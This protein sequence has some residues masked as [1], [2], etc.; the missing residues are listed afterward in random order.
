MNQ[1]L[2]V[3]LILVGVFIAGAVCGGPIALRFMRPPRPEWNRGA[4]PQVMDRLTKDLQLTEAQT[5]K[6]RPIVSR[7]QEEMQ[8]FRRESIRNIATVMDRMHT[9][10]AAE[11]TPEQRLKLEETRKRFRDRAERV[12]NEFRYPDRPDRPVK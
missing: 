5:E 8:H 3:I 9:D 10:V 12:R 6:I 2:K 4:R 11:L 7:A 1:R